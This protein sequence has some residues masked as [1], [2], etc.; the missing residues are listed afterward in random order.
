MFPEVLKEG[1][2]APMPHD[3]H[4][5]NWHSREEVEEGG[6]D[7]YAMA[8]KRVQASLVSSRG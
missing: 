8:L 2:T 7:L 3:L 1:I 4:S 5:L 6:T